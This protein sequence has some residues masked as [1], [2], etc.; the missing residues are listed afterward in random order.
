MQCKNWGRG[1]LIEIIHQLV[2]GLIGIE[3]GKV[4]MHLAVAVK[5]CIIYVLYAPTISFAI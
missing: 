5:V 2:G 3:G 4:T 1:Y